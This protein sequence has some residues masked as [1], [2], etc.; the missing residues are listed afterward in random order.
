[1][2][3]QCEIINQIVKPLR[4]KKC[5]YCSKTLE[6]LVLIIYP[7]VYCVECGIKKLNY[8]ISNKEEEISKAKESI[9]ELKKLVERL[10]KFYE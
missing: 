3:D 7:Y 1:M 6:F 4:V 9:L 2:G 5:D 8:R 10:G